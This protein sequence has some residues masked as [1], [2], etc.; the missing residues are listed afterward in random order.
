LHLRRVPQNVARLN[1]REATIFKSTPI[2]MLP[3]IRNQ[4]QSDSPP[5]R[6]ALTSGPSKSI[7]NLPDRDRDAVI[8]FFVD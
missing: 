3:T 8:Y 7:Q 6:I 1:Y 4:A 5:D 2:S